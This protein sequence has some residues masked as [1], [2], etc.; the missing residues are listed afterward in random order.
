MR[1]GEFLSLG[2][3]CNYGTPLKA[4]EGASLC[5]RRSWGGLGELIMGLHALTPADAAYPSP[6]TIYVRRMFGAMRVCVPHT[7]LWARH[8]AK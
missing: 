6:L 8:R 3:F 5:E 4:F 2:P 7:L 1:E